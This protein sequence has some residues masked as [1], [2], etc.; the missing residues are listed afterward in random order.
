[1]L[2]LTPL[3]LGPISFNNRTQN[4]LGFQAFQALVILAKPG[5]GSVLKDAEFTY[6]AASALRLGFFVF[7]FC[8]Q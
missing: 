5:K 1:M 6:F 7:I 4:L 2:N 3:F 8:V